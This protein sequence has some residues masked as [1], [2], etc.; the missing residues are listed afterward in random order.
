MKKKLW[1]N[2]A[3]CLNLSCV[4]LSVRLCPSLFLSH[5]IKAS[6]SFEN[7]VRELYSYK[8]GLWSFYIHV[9]SLIL[10]IQQSYLKLS[11]F[12]KDY[13]I[14]SL[15]SYNYIP[16]NDNCKTEIITRNHFII[17]S[18]LRVFHTGISCWFL[19]EV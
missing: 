5:T 18:L 13:F 16:I 17:C 3:I 7:K 4:R 14:S 2:I 1:V 12:T 6:T 15:K 10:A 9:S 19:T 11:L 8:T